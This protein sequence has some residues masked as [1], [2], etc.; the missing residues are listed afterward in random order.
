MTPLKVRFDATRLDVTRHEPYQWD[1][2]GKK[3]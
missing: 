3:L 2:V 1:A